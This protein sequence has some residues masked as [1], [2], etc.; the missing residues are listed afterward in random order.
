MSGSEV[1]ETR[2]G[3]RLAAA[4]HL[5]GAYHEMGVAGAHLGKVPGVP[6]QPLRKEIQRVAA[7]VVNL[8][9][10]LAPGLIEALEADAAGGTI[11]PLGTD[12]DSDFWPASAL[13]EEG[14]G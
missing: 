5:L 14:Q 13:D 3:E 4:E 1:Y 10:N 2:R 7:E 12:L 8:I 9:G 6:D 11:P